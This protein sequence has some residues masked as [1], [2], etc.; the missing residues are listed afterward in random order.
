MVAPESRSN[1]TPFRESGIP[2]SAILFAPNGMDIVR[3]TDHDGYKY[4]DQCFIELSAQY[5]DYFLVGAHLIDYMSGRHK[6]LKGMIVPDLFLFQ[7]KEEELG[8][9]PGVY[10]PTKRVVLSGFSEFKSGKTVGFQ[11]KIDGFIT[12]LE[13]FRKNP[14][15]LLDAMQETVGEYVELPDQIEIPEAYEFQI[16]L[17]RPINRR[18]I[19]EAPEGLRLD[20]ITIPKAA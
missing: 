6:P 16:S 7:V 12:L 14:Y 10:N 18:S 1:W 15:A 17:V 2:E 9:T 8:N 13:K 20:F 11:K 3:P 5:S 4:E 19:V